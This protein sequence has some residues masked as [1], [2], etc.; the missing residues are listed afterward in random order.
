MAYGG[1]SIFYFGN[2]TLNPESL[3]LTSGGASVE[4]EPQV[5]SL[6]VCLV[7]NRDRVMSKD[8]IIEKV[9]DGR[10][11]SDGTLNTRINAAR[12]AVGD[13]GKTQA[14]IKTFPRRG[15]RWVAE[16]DGEEVATGQPKTQNDIFDKP[17]IAVLPFENLSDD[18]DQEYFSD[19]ITEDI[20]NALS[21]LSLFFVI[22]RTTMF[23]YKSRADD[24]KSIAKELSA[25]YVLTGSVRKSGNRVRVSSQLVDGETGNHLWSENYDR[26]LEDV[27]AVQDEITNTVVAALESTLGRVEGDR[28][29]IKNPENLDAW[30]YYHRGMS[31]IYYKG[32][33]VS[34]PANI[35]RAK[36]NF[37]S[38]IEYDPKFSRA[39]AGLAH[40][41]Y[42]NFI[43]ESSE[44]TKSV[45]DE[46]LASATE[47]IYLDHEDAYAHDILG[48]IYFFRRDTK[49]AIRSFRTAVEI[50]PNF[51][52]SKF[53]LGQSLIASGN[54]EEGVAYIETA[55]TMGKRDPFRGPAMCWLSM[56]YLFLGNYEQ[57]LDWAE[58]A[59]SVPRVLYW[60]NA[61]LTAALS[62]LDR[63]D[64]A[65]EARKELQRRKP[66]FSCEFVKNVS[67]IIEPAYQ[68]ILVE[69]LRVAG[70]PEN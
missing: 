57:A 63:V 54:A 56:G 44:E 55:V 66:N 8:E 62:Y 17:S 25:R 2:Y 60:G 41:L 46:A 12:K 29:T 5:F 31:L 14:V 15:F 23:S 36:E 43:F 6:L 4:V 3:E 69:G 20:I 64:E 19:G 34:D 70:L 48:N 26:D 38:A 42:M 21:H 32:N 59:L 9:W 47:A 52:V 10:I 16:L 18:P 28:A 35:L 1:K 39:H 37:L 58:N 51:L 22:A 61:A 30:A 40:S 65:T 53:H 13:D 27:F 45:L 33:I 49:A 7:E 68:D 24:I 67:P 11:V 50:N